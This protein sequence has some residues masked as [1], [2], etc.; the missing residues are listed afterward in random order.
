[1][2]E[3]HDAAAT[4]YGDMILSRIRQSDPEYKQIFSPSIV[5][6]GDWDWPRPDYVC[7]DL[8]L[9]AS[10]AMEFKPPF[11]NKREY[12]TGLGQSIAYLQK[13]SYSGLI[14]PEYADDGF[15]IADFIN[16]TLKAPEFNNVTLSLFSYDYR[17]ES[18]R[19]L[20]PI[21]SL[22]NFIEISDSSEDVKTFWCWWRDISHYELYDL[23]N[24]SFIYG[25]YDGDIY[26]DHIYPQFYDMMVAGKTKQWDGSPRKKSGS[27]ASRKAEKQNYKIPLVQLEL[28]SRSEGRL[29]ELGFE[30]L[31]CGKKYG[32]NSKKFIDKLTYLILVNG[33][34]LDLINMVDKFQK[35]IP[36]AIDSKS[37][38]QNL[39]QFLTDNGCIGKRKPSAVKSGAKNSYVRDE[40]KL[41]NKLGLL[42]KRSSTEYFF[43]NEGYKFNWERITDVLR[44]N[45]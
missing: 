42:Y 10:Y 4:L 29:S 24:L 7:Y 1:M 15:R 28:W 40:M 2:G 22:R 37:H 30:L 35:I 39:E 25:D 34:H 5:R 33:R 32:P 3:F 12:L 45:I 13:H 41:W 38:A 11:Q 31:S 6:T 36:V 20:R 44:N 21:N 43:P 18:L 23:L 19:I 8:G 16:D 9:K 26:T 27:I 14:I 17:S